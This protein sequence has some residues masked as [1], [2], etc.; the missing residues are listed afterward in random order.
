[1]LTA[2]VAIGIG[3]GIAGTRKWLASRG[4]AAPRISA[5]AV[6]PLE[7]LSRDH[8]QQYFADGLTDALI[9]ISRGS[10]DSALRRGPP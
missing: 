3:A 7:N 6:I 9:T 1:M 5:L 4:S 2:G 10:G 8:E